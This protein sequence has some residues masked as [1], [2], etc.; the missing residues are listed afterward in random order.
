MLNELK[1]Y[2]KI[3]RF[4]LIILA[5]AQ[6]VLL[7]IVYI[8]IN[9]YDYVLNSN[10]TAAA[11]AAS[12]QPIYL[13]DIT[14]FF[15]TS[16]TTICCSAFFLSKRKQFKLKNIHYLIFFN[17]L[18]IFYFA[19]INITY[20]IGGIGEL[21]NILMP[22]LFIPAYSK[23]LL[24]FNASLSD[25]KSNISII[26]IILT[27]I[28]AIIKIVY[29]YLVYYNERISLTYNY[30]CISQSIGILCNIV[31]ILFYNKLIKSVN[32]TVAIAEENN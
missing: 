27:I 23:Y 4:T 24:D 11:A 22:I 29:A 6:A 15:L 14:Y 17:I 10:S 20:M 8:F 31:Y 13:L 16:I 25:K 18:V 7:L 3:K 5:I 30:Y 28:N 32:E 21:Y 9:P 19:L 1:D 2:L 12:T 26:L